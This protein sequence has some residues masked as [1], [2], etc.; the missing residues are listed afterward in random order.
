MTTPVHGDRPEL[1]SPEFWLRLQSDPAAL[2]ALVCFIDIVDLDT[3][4]Q[5]HAALH[6][7]INAAHEVA[8]VDEER[9]RWALTRD[10]AVAL[11]QA[12]G[13]DPHT[14]KP[15]TVDVLDA[16]ADSSDAVQSATA[17]LMAAQEKRGAL[18]AMASA[19]EDRKDM[20]IQ[21]AAKRRQEEGVYNR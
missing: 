15:K 4:L 3:T 8:R 12:R 11:L 10:R 9:A 13:V 7:W 6:A 14:K 16:E 20:L 18:R 1:G 19:L 17:A 2:A 21:I 5:H